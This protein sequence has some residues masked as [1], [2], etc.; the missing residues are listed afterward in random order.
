MRY[1]VAFL[2]VVPSPYQRDLFAALARREDVDLRVDYLEAAAPDSPWPEKPLPRYSRILPGFWF[3]VGSARCHVNP[4]PDYRG[5]D[6][7]ILNTIMSATAQWLMRTS[8]RRK[9]WI[10]WGERMGENRRAYH[11]FL[12][13]PLDRAAA[14]AGIGSLAD[15][16]Y[17]ARFPAPRH[18]CIPYHCE[19]APFMAEPRPARDPGEPVFLFCGQMIARKGLDHLLAAFA[20]LHGK[21][22]RARL[23]LAGREAELPGL[24]AALPEAVRAHVE[25]AGFQPPE[26]LPPLFAR[27]DVFILPSRHDGWGVV[28]NQALGAGLPLICSDTVGAAHDLVEP[29]VNGLRFPAG[30]VPALT[31]CMERLAADPAL[32]AQW[33]AASRA[34]AAAW[35]PD[36]GAEKWVNVFREVLGQ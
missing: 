33:G 25:Y 21:F 32:A 17:T 26:E 29:G 27:A 6:L 23:L 8:L 9:P 12:T 4:P 35:T 7:V 5:R 3:P 11:Q 10:F 16:Q 18:Y 1:R 20:V 36:R 28:V 19:L 30:D 24:L 14:I 31:H 22:P 34:K 2:S 13:A 15:R